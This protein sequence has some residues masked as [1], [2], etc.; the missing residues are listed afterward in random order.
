MEMQ[1]Q[2]SA[3]HLLT[4][5]NCIQKQ[6]DLKRRFT[7]KDDKTNEFFSSSFGAIFVYVRFSK[8]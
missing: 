4:A 1:N 2:S 8:I 3:L 6:H 5:Q 7:S